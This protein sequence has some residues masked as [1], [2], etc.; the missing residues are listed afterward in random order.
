MELNISGPLVGTDENGNSNKCSLANF[1]A[2]DGM[3]GWHSNE[4][5]DAKWL[6]YVQ[7]GKEHRNEAVLDPRPGTRGGGPICILL[8]RPADS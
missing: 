2:I 1:M 5:V 6:D 8:W 4:Y 3:A 7:A